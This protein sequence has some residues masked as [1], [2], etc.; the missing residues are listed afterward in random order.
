MR[1]CEVLVLSPFGR[2]T[3]YDVDSPKGRRS[4]SYEWESQ[5][6]DKRSDVTQSD[7]PLADGMLNIFCRKRLAES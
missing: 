1:F 2:E 4:E 3:V 7:T 6:E 5:T